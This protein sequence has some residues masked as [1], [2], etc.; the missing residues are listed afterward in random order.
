ML[1]HV[2]VLG[3]LGIARSILAAVLGVVLLLKSQQVTLEDYSKSRF[4][5]ESPLFNERDRAV[6]EFDRAAFAI[7]GVACIAFALARLAQ[8]IG[9]ILWRRWARR[10]GLGLACFDILNLALFPLSTALGLYGLVV[11]RKGETAEKF[12]VRRSCDSGSS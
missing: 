6:L 2:Q 3:M 10:L 11:Y 7:V 4:E 9:A 12:G 1:E 8:G 5:L